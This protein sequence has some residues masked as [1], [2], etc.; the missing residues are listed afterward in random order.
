M[1]SY[2]TYKA[3]KKSRKDNESIMQIADL[4]IVG[5]FQS[6]SEIRIIENDGCIR[7]FISFSKLHKLGNGNYA[8]P[9]VKN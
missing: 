3:A 1:R 8:I 7:N 5:E 6:Y 4:Y 9:E 2:K